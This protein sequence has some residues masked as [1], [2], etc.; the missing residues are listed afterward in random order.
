MHR[1][2]LNSGSATSAFASCVS[3][4][5]AKPPR[6]C[7]WEIASA[8]NANVCSQSWHEAGVG[9]H[10]CAAVL[11]IKSNHIEY[12]LII[13]GLRHQGAYS[14]AVRVR[15]GIK[16]RQSGRR[17]LLGNCTTVLGELA[18]R[19]SAPTILIVYTE[20]DSSVH[21][22]YIP[23]MARNSPGLMADADHV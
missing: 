9:Y 23:E 7:R 8:P 4:S 12:S 19:R 6:S 5:T 20:I 1:I 22:M 21:L 11:G 15:N 3:A 13:I 10:F 2:P 18:R 16:P 14:I 17:C